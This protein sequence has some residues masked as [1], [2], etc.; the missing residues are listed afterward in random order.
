MAT[1]NVIEAASKKRVF[2]LLEFI[3]LLG[4]VGLLEFIELTFN[5]MKEKIRRTVRIP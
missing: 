2:M 3:G 5:G 4:F 1:I